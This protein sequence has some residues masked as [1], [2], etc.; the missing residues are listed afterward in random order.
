MSKKN[1][2]DLTGQR[3][4]RLVVLSDTGKRSNDRHVIWEC[5]CD[6]GNKYFVQSNSLVSGKTQ[7]CGCF[8]KEHR[9]ASR[10]S[11]HKSNEKIY[12]VWQGMRKRCFSENHKNFKDYGGRGI[13]VC[14]K[15]NESFQEFYDYVSQ[16]PHFNEDGY[17]LDRID[18]N[19]NY[20][21]DNVRWATKREQANNRRWSGRKPSYE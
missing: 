15:W 10:I 12:G 3:F 20:E 13:T 6:C 16:L 8:Q 11:H 19:G 5:Q 1:K 7:S 4:G 2:K 21:P 14:D 9:G 17:T 18:N